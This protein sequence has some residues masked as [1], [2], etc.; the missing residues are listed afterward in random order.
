MYFSRVY[1]RACG[2]GGCCGAVG[3]ESMYGGKLTLDPQRMFGNEG[4]IRALG[5]LVRFWSLPPHVPSD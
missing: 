1:G 2:C 5:T 4:S 3:N